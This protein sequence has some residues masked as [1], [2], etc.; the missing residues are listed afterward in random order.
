MIRCDFMT[1]AAIRKFRGLKRKLRH[2]DSMHTG[3]IYKIVGLSYT[4]KG[5]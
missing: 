4:I 5:L 2:A 3:V 1:D